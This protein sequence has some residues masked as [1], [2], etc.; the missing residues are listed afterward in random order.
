MGFVY[1]RGNQATLL[2]FVLVG[3][4]AA[5]PTTRATCS[6]I[7]VVFTRA[8]LQSELGGKSLNFIGVTYAADVAGFEA[9]G[10][11]AGSK[12]LAA[13]VT[14]QASVCPNTEIVCP[15]RVN[16]I[17]MFGD[18]DNGQ[19]LPGVLNGKLTIFAAVDNIHAGDQIIALGYRANATQ[20]ANFVVSKL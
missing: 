5:T 12:T 7:T 11:A 13:D 16:E 20:D 3:Q 10:D 19:T 18:P 9:G 8:A 14:P 2:V 1:K 4:V 6:D 15:G 17:V